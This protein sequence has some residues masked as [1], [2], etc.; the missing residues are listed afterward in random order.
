MQNIS[1]LIIEDEIE[2]ITIYYEQ[3]IDLFDHVYVA[4]TIE[5]AKK[6]IHNQW[7]DG[8]LLDNYLPDGKGLALLKEI[9]TEHFYYPSIVVTATPSMNDMQKAIEKSVLKFIN[10]P[11]GLKEID[12]A[13]LLLKKYIKRIKNDI[14]LRSKNEITMATVRN[15]AQ[16]YNLTKREVEIIRHSL[17]TKNNTELAKKLYISQGTIK[18]HWQNIFN[19]TQLRSQDDITKLISKNNLLSY[20]E[21]PII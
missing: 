1:I 7:I 16:N 18:R 19:K 10:K 12:S 3:A 9:N 5:E 17:K 15:L 20:R 2:L 8:I 4:S 6:I 21:A 11:I 14:E 13:L